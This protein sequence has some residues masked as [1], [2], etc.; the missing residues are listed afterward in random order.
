MYIFVYM[1]KNPAQI[2]PGFWWSMF[3]T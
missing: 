2:E 3:A 1:K